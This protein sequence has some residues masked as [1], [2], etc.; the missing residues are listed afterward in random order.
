MSSLTRHLI[1]AGIAAFLLYPT[2]V[3]PSPAGTAVVHDIR[4]W[5][6]EEYT[7]VVID[8]K[9][10]AKYEANFLRAD[11]AR[12]LPPRI[13]IDIKKATLRDEIIRHPREVRN[14]LLTRVRAGRFRAGVVRVVID[15]ER[16]SGYR[17]FDL[18]D[19]SRIIVDVEGRSS[20]RKRPV[21]PEAPGKIVVMLD[22]G[23][24]GKDPGATGPTGLREKDV[25]LA[26][27]RMVRRKLSRLQ[28]FDVRMT[29]DSDVFI[30]LEERTAMANEANA[31]IFVSLHINS[32]R[33]RKARGV[34]TYV[35]SRASDREALE[36]A[37]RENG[38]SV[39]KLSEV[40][41]IIDDLSTYGRKK[42]S[43]RLAKTVNDAIVRNIKRRHGPVHNLGLKQ[44]PFYVLVGARMTAVLVESSFISN[45][46]EEKR[47]R[48]RSYL[49]TIADSVV[50][51]IRYYGEN[52]A[53][54]RAG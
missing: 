38:V 26:I 31:D 24:G 22:P 21:L 40:R 52:G 34:S 42:E 16:E 39:K 6:N 33:N 12:K 37:A 20:A 47:L 32:S 36:L 4:H 43:L 14:G 13:F 54:A 19:P 30:P 51:A 1:A 18:S 53:L 35:L 3:S 9:G 8:L 10:E 50:E 11:P 5:T 48:R 49:E 7:R 25:V 2:Y 23:H 45:R 27:G 28:G 17:V 15:L 46:G 41:F 44:A 29:R